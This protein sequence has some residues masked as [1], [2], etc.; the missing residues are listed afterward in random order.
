MRAGA[1]VA[2]L[3]LPELVR[4][5]NTVAGIVRIA[6][7][8]EKAALLQ[9]STAC[10]SLATNR[11]GLPIDE[12]LGIVV[13]TF[14]FETGRLPSSKPCDESREDAGRK[15]QEEAL[16]PDC[17]STR[18][19]GTSPPVMKRTT[20]GPRS[21][22]ITQRKISVIGPSSMSAASVAVSSAA[23]LRRKRCVC[24]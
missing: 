18:H 23:T 5:S 19:A 4:R 12:E 2:R 7:R 1:S 10:H 22:A 17:R 24:D 11:A 9:T 20:T 8:Q 3:G 13:L 6:V 14:V 21:R 15:Q 16:E